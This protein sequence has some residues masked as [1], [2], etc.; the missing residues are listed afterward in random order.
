MVEERLLDGGA[1]PGHGGKMDHR[2]V[3]RIAK[4]REGALQVTGATDIPFEYGQAA[5]A[6]FG[7]RAHGGNIGGLDRRGVKGIE[8]VD[9]DDS[10]SLQQQSFSQVRADETGASG[11]EDSLDA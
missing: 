8:V 7:D 6:T 2:R 11:D 10:K 5:G 9:D 1:H 3:R 4:G